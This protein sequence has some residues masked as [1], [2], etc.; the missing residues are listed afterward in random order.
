[1]TESFFK[2][3]T[4]VFRQIFHNI[5]NIIPTQIKPNTLLKNSPKSK[6]QMAW[7]GDFTNNKKIVYPPTLVFNTLDS[8]MDG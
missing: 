4:A 5:P 7:T 8:W 3:K 2:I 6:T 1:M